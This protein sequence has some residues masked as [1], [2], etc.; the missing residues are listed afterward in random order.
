[1][2]VYYDIHSKCIDSSQ[3][4]TSMWYNY[5]A[6]VCYKVNYLYTLSVMSLMLIHLNI[7]VKML[8][9]HADTIK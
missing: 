3:C 8:F 7:W 4:N 5:T 1:M 6:E 9:V 2:R